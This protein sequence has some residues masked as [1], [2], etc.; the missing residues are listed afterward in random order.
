MHRTSYS[1]VIEFLIWHFSLTS[2][3]GPSLEG[4]LPLTKPGRPAAFMWGDPI[5]PARIRAAMEKDPAGC[6]LSG[7][8]DHTSRDR[9]SH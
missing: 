4:F 6:K 8:D 5:K 3:A 9:N 7:H 2:P 1:T